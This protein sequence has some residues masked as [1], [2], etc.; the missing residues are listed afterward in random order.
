MSD[1]D[2]CATGTFAWKRSHGT[3]IVHNYGHGG[4]GVTLSWGCALEVADLVERLVRADACGSAD[5]LG[6]PPG[7]S[8]LRR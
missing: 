1:Y 3:R 7:R 4:S 2:R 6:S 5:E 8:R